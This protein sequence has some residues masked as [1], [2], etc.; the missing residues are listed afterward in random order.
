MVVELALLV[1]PDASTT[2]AVP[3]P[4]PVVNSRHEYPADR[5]VRELVPVAVTVPEPVVVT[6]PTKTS[7]VWIVGAAVV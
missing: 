1:L 3:A 6:K 2:Q 7:N 5:D 4:P